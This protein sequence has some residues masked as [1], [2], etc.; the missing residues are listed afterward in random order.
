MDMGDYGPEDEMPASS[1]TVSILSQTA[2]AM[3]M[4]DYED[5][6]P[7]ALTSASSSMVGILSAPAGQELADAA[8]RDV[9]AFE[10]VLVNLAA[11][12]E[13]RTIVLEVGDH[14]LSLRDPY[15]ALLKVVPLVSPAY[16]LCNEGERLASCWPN[17]AS[18]ALNPEAMRAKLC[19]VRR[20]STDE[21]APESA[22]RAP[23]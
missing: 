7:P 21:A 5:D 11:E 18:N 12:N 14:G 3:D 15:G 8:G 2:K 17:C 4:G 13:G 23:A 22:R 9:A 10:C 16:L 20:C 1:S 19:G 6:L